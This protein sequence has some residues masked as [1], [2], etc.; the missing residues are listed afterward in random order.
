MRT[1]RTRNVSP[2]RFLFENLHFSLGKSWRKLSKL[3][4]LKGNR[5]I[6]YAMH[7]PDECYRTDIGLDTGYMKIKNHKKLTELY[8]CNDEQEQVRQKN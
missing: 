5:L 4:L 3:C 6:V 2:E 7:Q 8:S 1:L